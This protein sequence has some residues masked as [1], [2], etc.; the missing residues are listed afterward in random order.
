MKMS[1]FID[2][3][4]KDTFVFAYF[5]NIYFILFESMPTSSSPKNYVKLKLHFCYQFYFDLMSEIY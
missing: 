4:A 5:K 3:N 2:A 1:N